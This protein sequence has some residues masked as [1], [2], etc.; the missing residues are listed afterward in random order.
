MEGK[1]NWVIDNIGPEPPRL[2]DTVA[3]WSEMQDLYSKYN[4]V[5]LGWGS[6]DLQPPKFLRDE[7]EKAM[8]IPANNNYGRPNGHPDLVKAVA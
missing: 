4:C 8:E 3:V 5:S 7:L 2:H 6:P 1:R